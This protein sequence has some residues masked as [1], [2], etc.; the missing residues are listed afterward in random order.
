MT[1][2]EIIQNA[3]R[4]FGRGDIPSVLETMDQRIDWN[5]PKQVGGPAQG[6]DKVASFFQNLGERYF[7]ELRVEPQSFLGDGDH[8]VALGRHR[9]IAKETKK[10]IELPFA[11]VWTLKN[12]KATSF[13]EYTDTATLA[14]ALVSVKSRV[15]A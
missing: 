3:Y 1:N 6:R 11:H 8:V 7:Q 10:T 12:G 14:E 13:H 9:A 4:A 5:A 15:T 2:V